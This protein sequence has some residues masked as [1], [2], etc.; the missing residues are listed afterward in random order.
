MNNILIT[1]Y[2]KNTFK[3]KYL[4]DFKNINNFQERDENVN[5]VNIFVKVIQIV[6]A[7]FW[8]KSNVIYINSNKKIF[9]QGA[10]DDIKSTKKTKWL[11]NEA[12]TLKLGYAFNKVHFAKMKRQLYQISRNLEYKPQISY[13]GYVSTP[14]A[15][16]DGYCLGDNHKY[17]FFD[18]TKNT[19][20]MYK[21]EFKKNRKK[22]NTFN[23]ISNA[24]EVD[25]IISSSFPI[26]T[27]I[28][29]SINKF[30]FMHLI[31]DRLSKDYLSEVFYYVSDFLDQCRNVNVKRVNLYCS[32]RQPVSFIIGMAIQNHHPQVYAYE[33]E[34]GRYAWA[35]NIQEGKLLMEDQ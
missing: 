1:L 16:F 5:E 22:T 23:I 10:L 28:T 14:F 31:A 12:K 29:R 7:F 19:G 17:I 15:I 26:N 27:E 32:S 25:L 6:L 24:A 11:I 8:K 2:V 13:G 33:L 34:K 4:D 9:D 30:E 21:I 3:A 18:T 20:K 35:V